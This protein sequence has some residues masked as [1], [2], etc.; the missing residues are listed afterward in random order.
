[1]LA[2]IREILAQ[3]E[4]RGALLTV[5]AGSVLCGPLLTFVPVLAR[6]AFHGSA[7]YF[8]TAMAAFGAGGLLGGAILL[9]LPASIDRRWVASVCA[10]A[11]G[12]TLIGIAVNPWAPALPVLLVFAGAFMTAANTAANSLLQMAASPRLLGR[13]VSLYSL[14]MRGGLSVGALLAGAVIGMLGPRRAFLIDG[15]A[16]VAVQGV[17]IRAWLKRPERHVAQP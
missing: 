4:L 8:A 7:G 2:G 9:G 15:V 11:L 5:L 6:V 12:A 1:M 13:T 16:A 3:S 17:L 14:A 10:I